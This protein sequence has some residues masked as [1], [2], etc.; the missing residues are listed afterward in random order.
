M[1][2]ILKKYDD[3]GIMFLKVEHEKI[4]SGDILTFDTCDTQQGM[5]FTG[6]EDIMQNALQKNVQT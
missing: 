6:E 2:T 5:Y 3:L 1:K 4:S